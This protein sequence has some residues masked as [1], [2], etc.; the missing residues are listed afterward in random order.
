MPYFSTLMLSSD[1]SV[2]LATTASLAVLITYLYT[3]SCTIKGTRF[4]IGRWS[5][6]FTHSNIPTFT[7]TRNVS[8]WGTGPEEEITHHILLSKS[9]CEKKSVKNENTALINRKGNPIVKWDT[10]SL[11]GNIK[12]EDEISIDLLSRSDILTLRDGEEGVIGRIAEAT[13]MI[14]QHCV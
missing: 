13:F 4:K 9:E 12:C 3:H 5:A 14:I 1:T 11:P 7:L 6:V 8:A 2:V 10:N